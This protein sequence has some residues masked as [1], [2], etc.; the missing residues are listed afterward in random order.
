MPKAQKQKTRHDYPCWLSDAASQGSAIIT[1]QE[2][3]AGDYIGVLKNNRT[4]N[5]ERI[6]DCAKG[7]IDLYFDIF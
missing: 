4:V 5:S 1:L 6:L 3:R 2:S 7:K